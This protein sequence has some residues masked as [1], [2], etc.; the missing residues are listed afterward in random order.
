MKRLLPWII[1][2]ATILLVI[3]GTL[4]PGSTG[5]AGTIYIHGAGAASFNSYGTPKAA[6]G[7]LYAAPPV[8]EQY[9]ALSFSRLASGR[10]AAVEAS[11]G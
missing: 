6:G 3:I 7:E 11:S 9:R 2:I 4:W 10:P 5:M 8:I 1:G